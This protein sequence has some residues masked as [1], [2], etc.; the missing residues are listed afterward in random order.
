MTYEVVVVGGGIGGLTVAALLAKR[1]LGV[2]LLERESQPGGCAR[3]FE[4][5]GY[6]FEP[7]AGLYH[8]WNEDGIHEQVFTELSID[9]PQT[10]VLEPS[11]LI[12]LPDNTQ[13]AVTHDTEE[14]EGSLRTTFPECAAAAIEFYR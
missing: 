1:G 2:C 4:K 11:Y 9:A 5:F 12:R 6:S 13:V 10:R 3:N 8:G 14:F 7:G